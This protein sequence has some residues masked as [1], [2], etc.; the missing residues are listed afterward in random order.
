MPAGLQFSVDNGPPQTA[1]QTLNLTS[2]S[3]TI[4]VAATQSGGAGTQYVFNSWSD[5]GAASHS[6]NVSGPATY[7][8]SFQTQYQLTIAA[9]PAA[10]G[11]VTPNSGIFYNSG[12]VVAISATAGSGYLFANWSGNVA[13]AGSASTTVTMNGPQTVTANFTTQPT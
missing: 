10:G 6:I 2:G 5:G 4:T 1:P 3:H 9:S 13:S 11:T 12:T 7:T 8:A